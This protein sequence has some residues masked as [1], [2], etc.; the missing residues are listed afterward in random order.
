MFERMKTGW[1]LGLQSFGVLR[2]DKELVLFPLMSGAACLLVLTSFAL[3]LWNTPYFRQFFDA[4]DHQ[5][6]QNPIVY[7]I[8]FAFYVVN[9]FVIVFFNAAL[10]SCALK[11]LAGGDP[12]GR[13]R[14]QASNGPLA[15]DR[16]LG[17]GQRHG[18]PGAED[19]RIEVG[20]DRPIGRVAGRRRLGDCDLL[21]GADSC[22]GASRAVASAQAI[23]EPDSPHL[24]RG[25]GGQHG[26]GLARHAGHDSRVLVVRSS[27]SCCSRQISRLPAGSS[28]AWARFGSHWCRSWARPS[29][30]SCSRP[31]ISTLRMAPRRRSLTR[32]C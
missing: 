1:N 24:G 4:Q 32:T 8:L 27:A 5:A 17:A 16:G 30:R 2:H 20:Q 3:P 15:A 29:N 12:D 7:V 11:R 28:S 21:R 18:R 6:P 22:G 25:A 19:D 9:Y 13:L 26:H 31:S 10:V 14:H 23:H